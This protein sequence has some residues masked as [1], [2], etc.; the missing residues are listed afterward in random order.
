MCRNVAIIEAE[1]LDVLIYPE[2]GM[3]TSTY[4][5]ALRRLAPVQI[6]THGNSVTCAVVCELSIN[7]LVRR[8]TVPMHPRVAWDIKAEKLKLKG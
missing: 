4:Y 3:H 6:S 7:M 5:L 2:I 1:Q 8:H